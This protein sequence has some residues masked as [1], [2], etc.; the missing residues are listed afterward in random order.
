[1]PSAPGKAVPTAAPQPQASLNR[2]NA[3]PAQPVEDAAAE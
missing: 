1:M 3:A 2:A